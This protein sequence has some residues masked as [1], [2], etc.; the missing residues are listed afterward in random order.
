MEKEGLS[1]NNSIEAEWQSIP[2]LELSE[3]LLMRPDELEKIMKEGELVETKDISEVINNVESHSDLVLHADLIFEGFLITSIENQKRKIPVIYKPVSGESQG[4]RE[5]KPKPNHRIQRGVLSWILYDELF[6][7]ETI[8]EA[9]VVPTIFRTDLP[10]GPGSLRPFLDDYQYTTFTRALLRVGKENEA[11][12]KENVLQS[13]QLLIAALFILLSCDPDVRPD[14][15]LISMP[16]ELD[17]KSHANTGRHRR[18]WLP[19][20]EI[21]IKII[22]GLCADTDY[23]SFNPHPIFSPVRLLRN[24]C[25]DKQGNKRE[26]KNV[27]ELRLQRFGDE[28]VTSLKKKMNSFVENQELIMARIVATGIGD[29]P[30][31]KNSEIKDDESLKY[32]WDKIFARTSELAET[33]GDEEQ[34]NYLNL[35]IAEEWPLSPNL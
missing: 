17:I 14:N 20:N 25:L 30:E 27:W 24:C 4:N 2:E 18:R 11:A 10:N 35:L 23:F 6:Q 5:D 15:Y 31:I 19:S 33:I 16:T 32:L 3:I 8:D 7:P 21:K 12:L 1:Q 13:Q 28:F 9:V 22:D 26:L 34:K 29:I